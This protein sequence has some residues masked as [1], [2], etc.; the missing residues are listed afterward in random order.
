M[1]IIIILIYV[2]EFLQKKQEIEPTLYMTEWFLC[3]FTRTLPWSALLR[4]WDMFLCEGEYGTVPSDFKLFYPPV[5]IGN[6]ENN[7]TSNSHFRKNFRKYKVIFGKFLCNFIEIQGKI[8]YKPLFF[9]KFWSFFK[10]FG[11]NFVN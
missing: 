6:Y 9:V 7:I 8:F 1:D 11:V 4:V 3:V 5:W 10:K 2:F